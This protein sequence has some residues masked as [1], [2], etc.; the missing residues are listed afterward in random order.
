VSPKVLITRKFFP[1][2]F[3]SLDWEVEFWEGKGPI[4]RERLLRRDYEAL[5]TMLYDKVDCEVL[6]SPRL[7]IVAQYTVGYD[8]VDLQCATSRG[9]YVTNTPDVLT[10]ATAELTWA[11]I[12]SV[13]RRVVEG[14]HFVRSGGWERHDVPWDPTLLLGMELRGKK[15]GVVGFGRIG[16]R[17]GEIGRGMG[18]TVV[19]WSR[20]PKKVSWATWSSLEDLFST[21]DVISVNVPLTPETRHLVGEGLLRRMKPTSVLVNTSRGLVVDTEALVN[22]LKRGGIAGA[23]LDVFEENHFPSL[24]PSPLSVTLCSFL[25]WEAPQWRPGGPWPA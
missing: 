15:L 14:D 19:Y 25:T 20:S 4:P 21:S 5:E 16:R 10:E 9:V 8:N 12:M 3:S 23:G 18:M 11:L 6:S 22:T 7:R 17:V 2:K 24:V 13:T 1:D